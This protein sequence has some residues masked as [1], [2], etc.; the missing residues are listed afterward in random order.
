MGEADAIPTTAIPT[1]T[2][3]TTALDPHLRAKSPPPPD[4]TYRKRRDFQGAGLIKIVIFSIKIKK[5]DFFL[6]KSD[7]YDL[8]QIFF[9]A[10]CQLVFPPLLLMF[11]YIYCCSNNYRPTTGLK[12]SSC[13]T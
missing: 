9:P 7:F 8:N 11:S 2:I 6:F 12:L 1:A 3:P 10:S 4:S 5:S 13:I